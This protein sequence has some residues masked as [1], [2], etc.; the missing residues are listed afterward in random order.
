MP[1]GPAPPALRKYFFLW[2]CSSGVA[3]PRAIS[4][5]V[6]RTSFSAALGMSQGKSSSLAR[7]LA[8]AVLLGGESVDDFVEGAVAAAGDDQ[9]AAFEGCALGDFRGV[10]RAGG[11]GK[12]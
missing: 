5:T 4:F 9:A 2:G 11:F 6:P 12:F 3:R 8:V 1:P 10:A 7:M